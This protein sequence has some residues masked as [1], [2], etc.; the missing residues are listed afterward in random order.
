MRV[1]PKY[2]NNPRLLQSHPILSR[3]V[4]LRQSLAIMKDFNFFPE[5]SDGDSEED[6]WGTDWDMNGLTPLDLEEIEQLLKDAK[7]ESS[8]ESSSPKKKKK[9]KE[10]LP[11][12]N[13]SKKNAFDLPEPLFISSK[14]KSKPKPKTQP[15]STSQEAFGEYTALDA[16]DAADKSARKKSLQFHTSRI[17]SVASKRS[18]ARAAI[19]GDEDI[20]Y[21]EREKERE[22][23]LQR[24]NRAKIGKLGQGGEAL[25]EEVAKS[26]VKRPR[27]VDEDVEMGDDGYYDLV[28]KQTREL[29]KQKKESYEAQKLAER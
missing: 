29:K 28:E 19:G 7:L 2:L 17:E 9:K 18:K 5:D 13:K 10:K 16:V 15:Q 27:E 23:R 14:S 1:S 4:T 12:S 26:G 20:P 6:E 24:E 8:G 25:E 22:M 21:R 11:N 3:L